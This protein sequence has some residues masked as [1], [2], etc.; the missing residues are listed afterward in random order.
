MDKNFFAERVLAS[1]FKHLPLKKTAKSSRQNRNFWSVKRNKSVSGKWTNE[2]M[3]GGG[4][5]L[6]NFLIFAFAIAA[7]Q[8]PNGMQNKKDWHFACF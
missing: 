1:D 3:N 7:V 6:E 4:V 8:K 5:C 2:Q